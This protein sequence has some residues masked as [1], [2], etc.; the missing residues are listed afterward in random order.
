MRLN[1]VEFYANLLRTFNYI[2][3]K[4]LRVRHNFVF[5]CEAIS[6]TQLRFTR[7]RTF[8][9][10]W[11]EVQVRESDFIIPTNSTKCYVYERACP[12][13]RACTPVST[14]IFFFR[15][16]RER[17]TNVH[18]S[19]QVCVCGRRCV[20]WKI[21]FLS[22]RERERKRNVHVSV[23]ACQLFF[24]ERE[25][26]KRAHAHVRLCRLFKFFIVWLVRL[27]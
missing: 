3:M 13:A 25:R 16:E 6:A 26:D 8:V 5:A 12:C 4:L 18:A 7:E 11:S 22:E 1:F 14:Y 10:L 24:R 27:G 20:D 23:Q 2:D 17:E 9:T 19:M 21:F 15:S